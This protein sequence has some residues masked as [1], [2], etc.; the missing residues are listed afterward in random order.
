MRVT[1][2]VNLILLECITLITF[3]K[4]HKVG[5]PA[6]CNF[7]HSPATLSL[8]LQVQNN[9]LRTLHKG[10]KACLSQ[11]TCKKFNLLARTEE[12][13]VKFHTGS[14]N[15]LITRIYSQEL[16][17][18]Q[19]QLLLFLGDICRMCGYANSEHNG[20]SDHNSAVL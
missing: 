19:T 14:C 9:F 5:S 3:G 7:L 1:T 6:F 11:S 12:T 4:R 15:C 20:A 10:L 8:P 13:A 2:N 16:D 18:F 17:E